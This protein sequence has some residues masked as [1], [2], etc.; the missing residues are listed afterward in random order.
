MKTLISVAI[1]KYKFE[2]DMKYEN[3]EHKYSL[4]LE[5]NQGYIVQIKERT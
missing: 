1:R 5:S 4:F 2:T 3:L